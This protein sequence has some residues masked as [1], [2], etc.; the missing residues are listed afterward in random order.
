MFQTSAS[1]GRTI[2]ITKGLKTSECPNSELP[3]H[4][5]SII[6][7]KLNR[8]VLFFRFTLILSYPLYLGPVICSFPSAV[9]TKILYVLFI[10]TLPYYMIRH[11][12]EFI[13][14]DLSNSICNECNLWSFSLCTSLLPPPSF[15]HLMLKWVYWPQHLVTK[16]PP[17]WHTT[18]RIEEY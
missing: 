16:S 17:L 2:L 3:Q 13:S 4:R 7:K 8:T 10:S 9:P 15:S 12:W 6:T 18:L 14:I 5:F 11:P 1:P